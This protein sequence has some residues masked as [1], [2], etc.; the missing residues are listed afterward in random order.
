MTTYDE[1]RPVGLS[2]AQVALL[3]RDSAASAT[4]SQG[5]LDALR[6]ILAAVEGSNL[7]LDRVDQRVARIE[8]HLRSSPGMN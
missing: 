8:E 6:A 3:A 5:M 1:Y 4:I 2:E 7:H